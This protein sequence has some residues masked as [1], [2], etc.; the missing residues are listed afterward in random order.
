MR[1]IV[2]AAIAAALTFAA[3]SAPS[4]AGG[5]MNTTQPTEGTGTSVRIDH[6]QFVAGVL[7]VPVGTT[8]KWTNDDIFPHVVSGIAWGQ[9]V[10]MLNTGDTF[11]HTFNESGIYPYTCTLHPGMSAV[12]FVGDVAAPA[13]QSGS[14]A[15]RAE[16]AT[17]RGPDGSGLAAAVIASLLVGV[18][19]FLVGRS[20]R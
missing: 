13:A 10:P 12:V 8:V 11:S 20:F 1:R 4:L 19:S 7:R 16:P 6:C 3:L 17:Q 5:C 15:P 2:F 18:T 9:L 14:V